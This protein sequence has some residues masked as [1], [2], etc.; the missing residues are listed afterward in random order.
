MKDK[1]SNY[2]SGTE[3][4]AF[5]DV[6]WSRPPIICSTTLASLLLALLALL[7]ASIPKGR[8]SAEALYRAHQLG[9]EGI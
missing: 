7:A 4:L 5:E 9:N 6:T 3:K 1:Q 2:G 8:R